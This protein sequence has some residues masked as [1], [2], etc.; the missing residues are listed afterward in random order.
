MMIR[1]RRVNEIAKTDYKDWY[2]LTFNADKLEL[3]VKQK[4]IFHDETT[5]TID[6]SDIVSIEEWAGSGSDKELVV[7]YN[8]K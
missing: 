3:T 4:N 1:I 8:N 2:G 5:I 6:H 7:T